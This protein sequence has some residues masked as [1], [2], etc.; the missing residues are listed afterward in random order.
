MDA[1][2]A[3]RGSWMSPGMRLGR[4]A[5][6]LRHP[7]IISR[8]LRQRRKLLAIRYRQRRNRGVFSVNFV[9]G[10]GFFAHLTWCVY[11]LS[12]CHDRGLIPHLTSDNPLYTDRE[13]GPDF[14]AY[15]FDGPGRDLA[16]AQI[17]SANVRR[18]DELGL[19]TYCIAQMTLERAA[20]LVGRYMRIRQEIVGEV[21]RFVQRHFSSRPVLGAQ[22]R[23]TDKG[24]EAP[25]VSREQC[26]EAVRRFLGEHPEVD[27]I[28]VASDEASFIRFIESEFPSMCV[29][30]CDDQRS[31][32]GSVAVHRMAFEGGNYEKGRQALVNCLLLS[33]CDV[34]IRTASSLSGWASVFNL[35]LPVV[36]LNRPYPKFLWF[37]DRCVVPRAAAVEP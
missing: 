28:F 27:R 12:Y 22:F 3:G 35:Q 1:L 25:P 16:R 19:P 7:I 33:R 20:M 13:R 36:M 29:C 32:G 31:E 18:I 21:D 11:A 17:E 15:F 30:S 6:A 34:L 9:R 5:N 37:P 14:L 23:G 2:T 4:V 8:Y 24:R 10:G 26:G